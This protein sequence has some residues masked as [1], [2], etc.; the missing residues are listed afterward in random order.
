VQFFLVELIKYVMALLDNTYVKVAIVLLAVYVLMQMQKDGTEHLDTTINVSGEGTQVMVGSETV[1]DVPASVP[2]TVY[3]NPAGVG[4]E[5]TSSS[6]FTSGLATVDTEQLSS[7]PAGPSQLLPSG[8]SNVPPAPLTAVS[9]ELYAAAPAVSGETMAQDAAAFTA[10]AVDFDEVF[11]GRNDG[12]DASDLVPKSDLGGLYSDIVPDP[13]FDDKLLI[14]SYQIGIETNSGN[15]RWI[16]DP[17]EILYIP[18]QSIS[19]WNNSSIEIPQRRK[20]FA[21]L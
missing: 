7:G 21:D 11:Q 5:S 20:S 12:L 18:K 14:N 15:K 4:G 3:V 16:S 6:V 19:P 17:R 2:T 9:E 1:A 10:Q 13:A 8:P